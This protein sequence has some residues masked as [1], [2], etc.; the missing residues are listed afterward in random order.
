ML[1]SG[2]NVVPLIGIAKEKMSNVDTSKTAR[3]RTG[4]RAAAQKALAAGPKPWQRYPFKPPRYMQTPIAQIGPEAEDM[5][6]NASMD[7]LENIGILFLDKESC[8]LL[9]SIGCSVD[10]ETQN[11][12]MGR[13]LVEEY[14][15]YAPSSFKIHARNPEHTLGFGE[16]TV[17]FALVGSPPNYKD[18]DTKRSPGTMEQYKRMLKLAQMANIVHLSG[19]FPVE[20]VD[21]HARYRHLEAVKE[22][23]I[24][25]DKVMHGY[26]L[27]KDRVLDSYEI[28]RI[29]SGKTDEQMMAEPGIF[30]NINTSS[31]LRVDY[32]MLV[33]MREMALRGQPVSN[34]PFTLSGAMAPA[35]VA[36]AVTLQN[37]EL[38]A[39]I[40]FCQAVRKGTPVIYGGFTP[41]V[42]MKSG[43]P[44]FGTPEYIQSSQLT[45]QLTRR[46]GLPY[47]ASNANAANTPDAQAAWESVFSLWGCI[48]GQADLIYHSAGWMEG[49]LT[50]SPEKFVMDLDMLQTVA[51][52]MEPP[53][54]SEEALGV[55]AIREV[56]PG[57]HYFGTAHTMRRYDSA[58]WAPLVSDW[59]NHGSWEQAGSPDTYVRANKVWKDMIA[60]YEPPPM[61]PA[62]REE[63]DAFVAKRTEEGGAAVDF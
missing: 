25:T 61:E 9:E 40:V 7:V 13:E 52:A 2:M 44:A 51:L 63:L 20:P 34:T 30:T 54:V 49:G 35:T 28:A 4:G 6:H 27:G 18:L 19:G 16:G 57:G 1:N 29:A 55:D 24:L 31:P 26:S 60:A 17:N 12:R 41:N 62:I 23:A 36:G 38:L 21:V 45:G 59:R 3:R 46:Y 10:H 43:A 8:E 58:F 56:G 14:V 39:C 47:R 53:E 5:I 15:S 22:M 48:H 37:A 11:V 32:L 33:G 42:D 50:A